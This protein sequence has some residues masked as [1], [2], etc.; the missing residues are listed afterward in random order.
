M[1][2]G[3]YS[4]NVSEDISLTEL[5]KLAKSKGLSLGELFNTAAIVAFSKMDLQ[6]E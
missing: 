1:R 5:K 6:K 3:R 4:Y 2:N